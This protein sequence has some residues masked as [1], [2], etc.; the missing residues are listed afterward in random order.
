MSIET[1][2]SHG[3]LFSH[4]APGEAYS[5]NPYPALAA[6]RNAAPCH[7]HGA[8]AAW[9]ISDYH[10]IVRLLGDERTQGSTSFADQSPRFRATVVARL[11]AELATSPTGAMQQLVDRV[12]AAQLQQVLETRDAELVA[13]F[14]QRVPMAVM[15]E[16]LG[17]PSSDLP[18][19]RTLSN[20]VLDAFDL[21]WE[22]HPRA[23]QATKAMLLAY[24]NRHLAV[25]RRR[26]ATPL[27]DVLLHEQRAHDLP[28]DS[29]A[30][31]C[32][33]LV[34]AGSSTTAGT[35]ANILARLVTEGAPMPDA[36]DD[37][38]L[39]D[40]TEELL[41]LDTPILAL[42]RVARERVELPDAVIDAGTRIYLMIA[43][44]NRDPGVFASADQISQARHGKPH[45][46]FGP[47]RHHCLGASLARLEIRGILRAIAPM[48]GRLQLRQPVTWRQ[49]WLVHEASRIEVT[50]DG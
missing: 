8:R 28:E 45:L 41:R 32:M 11:R 22:G 26:G 39:R 9:L 16:L 46:S 23:Y 48:L 35:L 7:Y 47:G 37:A 31:A 2:F 13:G 19:L 17:M 42:K 1:L 10:D 12:V 50:I 25:A 21:P 38:G 49:G 20:S 44:A 33:K 24:F 18:T 3:A 34:T 6:L 27:M 4:S 36:S 5:R 14:A 15:A 43:A 29:I 30:D 40:L